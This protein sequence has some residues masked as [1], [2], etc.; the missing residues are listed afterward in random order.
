MVAKQT[1]DTS[2]SLKSSVSLDPR[3]LDLSG[4]FLSQESLIITGSI[5]FFYLILVACFCQVVNDLVNFPPVR[6]PAL[7]VTQP[8]P[9]NSGTESYT[10]TNAQGDIIV[11]STDNTP[12]F[13]EDEAMDQKLEVFVNKIVNS[14]HGNFQ[15]TT[16]NKNDN[17]LLLLFIYLFIYS[18]ISGLTRCD[19]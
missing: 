11:Q 15:V 14:L 3:D 7:N 5:V 10:E 17:L 9:N 8:D 19:L 6:N 1:Y 18:F 16:N 12:E 2:F 13:I 4:N